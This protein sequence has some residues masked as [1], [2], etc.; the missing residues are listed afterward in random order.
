MVHIGTSPNSPI[1]P[2]SYC[3]VSETSSSFQR[4]ISTE[5]SPSL[6]IENG[7]MTWS[8]IIKVHR[9]VN[10]GCKYFYRIGS[11]TRSYKNIFS[12]NYAT[13]KFQPIRETEKRSRDDLDVTDWLK[14]QRS[15]NYTENNVY[16]IGSWFCFIGHPGCQTRYS[17]C[18]SELTTDKLT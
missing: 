1:E 7:H 3:P 10:W 16:R 8:R 4:F 12:V 9:R 11:W 13:L 15:V 18:M 17:C 2:S 6:L 5:I 14:F